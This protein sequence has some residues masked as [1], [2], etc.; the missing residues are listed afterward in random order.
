MQTHSSGAAVHIDPKAFSHG[1]L[2]RR[3]PRSD[4]A[5]FSPKVA[6]N[7]FRHIQ[8][9]PELTP[10]VMWDP[11]CGTGLIACVA[12]FAF[13]QLFDRIVVSDLDRIAV[14]CA[15][16]NTEILRYA[17]SYD[18]R[19]R[20]VQAKRGANEG[21]YRRWGDVAEY[22][23][24]IRGVVLAQ[25]GLLP[26]VQA[27]AGSAFSLPVRVEGQVHFVG[28]LPY[29]RKSRLEGGTIR[30]V[31]IALRESHRDSTVTLVAPKEAAEVVAAEGFPGAVSRPLKGGRV[32]LRA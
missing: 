27:V 4:A 24:R 1:R 15:K 29:G 11:F 30:D 12:L 19:H 7:L 9:K 32:I 21:M 5:R 10:Q 3:Y 17:R 25:Q 22:M 28:D 8:Q 31:L 2:F 16:A 13:P 6:V 26:G 18:K 20:E 23:A 14:K